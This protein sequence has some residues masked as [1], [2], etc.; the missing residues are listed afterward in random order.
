MIEIT[1]F[2]KGAQYSILAK[3]NY[4]KI[5]QFCQVAT[6]PV[7]MRI[8]SIFTKVSNFQWNVKILMHLTQF[9]LRS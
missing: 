5:P 1:Y 9:E 4:P 3:E 7:Y 6:K 2:K 8:D